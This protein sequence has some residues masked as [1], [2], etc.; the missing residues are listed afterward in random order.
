ME[1]IE[2]DAHMRDTIPSDTTDSQFV[3]Q[4]FE[5]EAT[6]GNSPKGM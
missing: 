3:K 2:V 5:D 4:F 6:Q 1:T